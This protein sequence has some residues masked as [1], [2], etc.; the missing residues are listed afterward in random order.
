M[1]KEEFIQRF[2]PKCFY[3]FTDLRN[4]PSI[5]KYGLL[6]L[7]EL[8]K[9]GIEGYY[10][11]GNDW[12][13]DADSFKGLDHFVHLCLH[14]RHPMEFIAR[15]KGRINNTVFLPVS[16]D[17][18]GLDGVRFTEGVSNKTGVC[19]L[20]PEKAYSD[21]DFEVLYSNLDYG[22]SCIKKR[23]DIAVKYELLVPNH[24][25]LEYLKLPKFV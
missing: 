5:R 21:L 14:Y 4:I 20:H 1:N 15:E 12:S 7:V 25:P 11:G 10:P 22:N 18:L 17:I 16:L 3:H 6:S 8:A 9:Q 19:L 13:H 2:Q 23:L 24:I